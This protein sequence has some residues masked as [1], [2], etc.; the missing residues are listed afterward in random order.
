VTNLPRQRNGHSHKSLYV[1]R[2]HI[3]QLQDGEAVARFEGDDEHARELARLLDDYET[4]AAEVA[5]ALAAADV[6]ADPTS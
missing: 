3:E 5:D 2:R 6:P 4:Y 1:L